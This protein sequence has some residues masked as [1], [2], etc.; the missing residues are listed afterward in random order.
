MPTKTIAQKVKTAAQQYGHKL[1][2]ITENKLQNQ[3]NIA[4]N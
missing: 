4:T 1:R 2:G 3:Q